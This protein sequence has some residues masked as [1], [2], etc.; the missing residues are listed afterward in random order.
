M[1]LQESLFETLIGYLTDYEDNGDIVEICYQIL[2]RYLKAASDNS[3][4]ENVTIME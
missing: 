2:D 3:S 4:H 1:N